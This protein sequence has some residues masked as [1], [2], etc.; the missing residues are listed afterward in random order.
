MN[1][2]ICALDTQDLNEAISWANGLRDKVGMV[3]LGLEFFAAHGPSGVREVAKC[4][5]PIFLDLKLYDIPNTVART[6]EAIKALD[7]E[8]LTLHISGGT[9][10]LKEALSIVQGKK[11][12]LIGV[13]VLTSMGNEDLSELGV[14]REAKSQV[15]LLAKLAKK[16]G[17][18]GVVCSAL[19]AQEV[20][21]ECGKD[22]KIITPG[23]RMNR[24]HDDQKRTA[25]PKEAINS[26]ADYIVIGRPITKSGNP[27]SSAEL[28]LKSLTD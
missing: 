10:M 15:I 22:F 16:I 8:M 20:R 18:H 14:A 21:Q 25:T 7:V 27:A 2:I 12:K 17:L 5:V 1:P 26:G 9:K 19:E 13:T 4:N 24:G 3:K 23:I 28:I 6:V 11:I